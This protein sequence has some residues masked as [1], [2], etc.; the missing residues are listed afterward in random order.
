MPKTIG[1][2]QLKNTFSKV[3]DMF[4]TYMFVSDANAPTSICGVDVDEDDLEWW[5]S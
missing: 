4:N 2:F 5:D 1:Y 3:T